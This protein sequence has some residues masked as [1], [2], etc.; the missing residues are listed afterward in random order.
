MG[1]LDK[2]LVKFIQSAS[3][4]DSIRLFE[5][6][7]IDAAGLTLDEVLRLRDKGIAVSVILICDISAGADMLLVRPGIHKLSELKGHSIAVEES[8]LG[9]LMLYQILQ[10]S[11]LKP[12]DI[13]PVSITIDKQVEAWKQ[14]TVDAAISYEPA[15]SEIIKIGGKKLFDSRQI[16]NFI[17]DVIAVR[18]SVLN[19]AH[20]EALR[21]LVAAHLKGLRY[22]N[23]N[24]NDVA[25]R[26]SP[27]FKLPHDQVMATFK[28][29]VLP[30]LYNN[31]RLFDTSTSTILNRANIIACVMQQ[32]GILR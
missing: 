18:A 4:T 1:W 26:I 2:N 21:H 11:G 14:G 30:N 23:I 7:K 10:S 15:A 32:A 8:T 9:S 3:A 27:R 20:A 19:D 13:R 28:G 17:F 22:I 25:Y 31:I 16:P 5:E 12:E 24:P 6:G 29:L